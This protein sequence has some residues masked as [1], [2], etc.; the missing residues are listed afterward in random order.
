VIVD[1]LIPSQVTFVFPF[2]HKYNNGM[3]ASVRLLHV[4]LILGRQLRR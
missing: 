4:V 3:E 2:L 1:V